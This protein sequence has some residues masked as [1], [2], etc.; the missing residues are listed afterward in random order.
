MSCSAYAVAEFCDKLLRPAA[1]PHP[2]EASC[3]RARAQVQFLPED[4]EK[5]LRA[6]APA[7]AGI[8]VVEEHQ[9]AV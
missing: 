7:E 5:H 4:P 8:Q 2:R 3:L 1:P 6:S 9:A